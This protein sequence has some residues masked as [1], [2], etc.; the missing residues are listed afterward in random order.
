ME[1]KYMQMLKAIHTAIEKWNTNYPS[2]HPMTRTVG[3]LIELRLEHADHFERI[4]WLADNGYITI[5]PNDWW[6]DMTESYWESYAITEK[7]KEALRK[8][9]ERKQDK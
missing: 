8:I 1:E 9:A 6:C 4:D 3:Y 7:G 2:L 5:T